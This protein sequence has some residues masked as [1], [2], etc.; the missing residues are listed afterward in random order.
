MMNDDKTVKIHFHG[1][2]GFDKGENYLFPSKIAGSG[3][4]YIWTIKDETNDINYICYIGETYLFSKRHREHL[5]EITGLNYRIIDPVEARHGRE[6]VIWNGMWRDKTPDAAARLLEN[7]DKVAG[8]VVDY[9]RLI[10]IYLAPIQDDS[11]LRKHIEG[12]IGLNLRQKH[13]EL[14]IFYPA[15]NYVRPMPEKMGEKLIITADE[16][17]AGLDEELLI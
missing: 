8:V 3:G 11:R 2:F 6:K 4:I 15:D 13:P 14:N 1:P 9:I 7:Y 12:C 5:L 16:K 17:I 10:N